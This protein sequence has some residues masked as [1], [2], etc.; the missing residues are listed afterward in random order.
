MRKIKLLGIAPYDELRQSMEIVS[1]QFD[2]ID[3]DVFTANLE[4]GRELTRQLLTN[5]YDAIISRGGTADLIK[6]GTDLPVIDV[7]ISIYDVL[8]AIQ[9]ASNYA[10][11]FAI[12]GFS[13]I[14]E[15]AYLLCNIL[16]YK[17]KIITLTDADQVEEVLE[18]LQKSGCQMVLCDAITHHIALKKSLNTLLI[19]SGVESIRHAF[20]QTLSLMKQLQKSKDYSNLL[21]QS[22]L[23]LNTSLLL[24]SPTEEVHFSN[25][26]SD[27]QTS[28]LHFL[29]GKIPFTQ[30]TYYHSYKKKIYKLSVET[31]TV[32]DSLYYQCECKLVTPL[33]VN[34][35][36]GVTYLN[37]QEIENII[38]QN[39]LFT[40]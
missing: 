4:Q 7:S 2:T 16:Q 18:N 15:T 35:S 39:L 28:V 13:S 3:I 26:D 36:F 1:Q 11:D 32:N 10:K 12:V 31:I 33:L 17:V 27:L 6:D 37:R 34:N 14:T 29:S 20:E 23:K 40:S 5:D 30:A 24:L 38:E 25:L 9:L 21:T 8:S 22:L 19:T